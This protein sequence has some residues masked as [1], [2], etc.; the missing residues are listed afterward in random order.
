MPL[1]IKQAVISPEQQNLDLIHQ[2]LR[3]SEHSTT[4]FVGQYEAPW[5]FTPFESDIWH[6]SNRGREELI[7]GQWCFTRAVYWNHPLPDGSC[8]TD[9]DNYL[10]LQV[11][12]KASFLLRQGLLMPKLAPVTW[13]S[14]TLWTMQLAA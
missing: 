8:L 5:L 12:K 10:L 6:T 4:S 11:L 13:Y 9:S 7:A 3:N 14:T 1:L 2:I